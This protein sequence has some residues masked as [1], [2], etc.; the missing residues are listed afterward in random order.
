MGCAIAG[1]PDH[2]IEHV[3]LDNIRLAFEGGGKRRETPVPEFPDKYPE[4]SMFGPLPAYGFWCRHVRDLELRNT[5]LS[6]DQPDE[7]PDVV[8]DDV[9]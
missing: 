9:S 2:P 5:R 6:T 3:I 4:Y 1:L 8:M 7:R